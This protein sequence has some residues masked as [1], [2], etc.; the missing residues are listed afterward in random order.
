MKKYFTVISLILTF[1]NN[2]PLNAK[3]VVG[4]YYANYSVYP[5]TAIEYN[6]L[7]HIAHAFVKPNADGS[8]SMDSWFLYP[9]LVAAAHQHGIKIVVALGGWGNSDGFSP[10]VANPLTRAAFVSNI[11]DFCL[12]NDYDGIDID[13]EYPTASDRSNFVSLVKELREALN[14]VGLEF[15]SIALPSTDWNNG[16][17]VKQLINYVNW[18]GIMTYDFYGPWEKT[19]GHNSPLYPSPLQSSSTSSSVNYYLQ[20]GI[21]KNKLCIG[22]PFYGYDFKASELFAVHSGA[23]AINYAS[24]YQNLISGWDYFWDNTAKVPYLMNKSRTEVITFDDTNSI[25]LK[26]EYVYKNNL[27]GT[28]IWKIGQDYFNGSTPLLDIVEKYMLH[29]PRNVP[30]IPQLSFPFNG[31]VIDSD[32]IIFKWYAT[33][34][35]TSYNLQVSENEN[36]DSFVINESGINFTEAK[37]NNFENN[38]TYYWRVSSSNING[39]SS[40]SDT[41]SFITDFPAFVANE[42]YAAKDF[43]LYNYPNPFN[44]QTKIGFTI[45]SDA[46]VNLALYDI[47]GQQRDVLVNERLQSGNYEFIWDANNYSSGVYFVRINIVYPQNNRLMRLNKSIKILLIK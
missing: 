36:F 27:A 46:V 10:M 16:Y 6:K 12:T 37:L 39:N 3:I 7:T 43:K 42:Y 24:V 4:Y 25:K 41:W 1:F 40:W 30:S 31:A 35:T 47:L 13:W 20:K 32:N 45:A 15:L 19:S 2:N 22:I 26:S 8:L 44:V 23:S 14:N 11:I 9:E 34:S 21:P 28:I 33:D 38:K 18:F 29:H 17:D 5:Y